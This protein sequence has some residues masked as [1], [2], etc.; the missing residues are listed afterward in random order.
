[1]R[2]S[3][4]EGAAGC[5][6][7]WRRPA[8]PPCPQFRLLLRHQAVGNVR[9]RS[10][11]E[12]ARKHFRWPTEFVSP[13]AQIS[14]T[15]V[16]ILPAYT[17]RDTTEWKAAKE[18]AADQLRCKDAC[19]RKWPS[20]SSAPARRSYPP[21]GQRR[22]RSAAAAVAAREPACHPD[23]RR[24]SS[25][26]EIRSPPSASIGSSGTAR[27]PRRL[28]SAPGIPAALGDRS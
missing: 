9:A 22:S 7:L 2:A 5:F 20:R 12:K 27:I 3:L 10:S 17:L 15:R 24:A 11:V 19:S 1:M 18:P 14:I 6:E 21:C 23:Y 28:E 26:P 13:S 4:R 25:A 8:C 16:E